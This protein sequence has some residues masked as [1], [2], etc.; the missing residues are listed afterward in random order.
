MNIF[1]QISAFL[2]QGRACNVKQLVRK[3]LADGYSPKEI[4]NNGLMSGMK[5]IGEK[6]K[7]DEVYVPEVLLASR[8]MN[9]GIELLKPA[10]LK[11]DNQ[12]KGKVI[13]GTVKGDL[14]DIGKNLVRIML[15]SRNIKVIDLGVNVH[16]ENFVETAIKENAQIIACSALLTTTIA[17]M[18]AVVALAKKRGIRDNVKIMVG[19]A[20]LTQAYCNSIGADYYLSD[21]VTASELSLEI[22]TCS[23]GSNTKN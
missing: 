2:Q 1:E 8:A 9:V 6:Y 3:A 15:E 5:I 16:A 10:F 12:P 14:H 18:K 19:G 11:E 7:K 23:V 22:L 20:P 17:E 21:A 13:L 4:L